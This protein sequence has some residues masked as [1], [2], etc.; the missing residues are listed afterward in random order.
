[1]LLFS[2]EGFGN[3][4]ELIR[5]PEGNG[6][7]VLLDGLFSPGEWEDA[8]K[9][10]IHQNVN[11][12]LKRYGGHVFIG[13]KITPYKTSVV[14]MFISP[15]GESIHHL[16]TS[17]QIGE[18]LVN[19][20][21]GPWDNPSF[22]WGYSVDWYANEIRWDNGKMEDLM[23]KGKD[24]NEAQEMSYFT[25][26]GFEFQIRQSKFSSDQWLFRIE[27]PMAPD[28]DKPVIYPSGTEMK[29]TK[30]WVR[31]ELDG[32]GNKAKAANRNAEM[33]EISKAIDSCIGWFKTKDFKLLFNTIANDPDY[34]SIHPSNRIVRGFEQFKKNAEIY[35]DPE[36]QYVRHDVNDL[37]INISDS[38]DIAWFYCV[39][40]DI[41]TWKGKPATWENTRWT[42]VLEKREGRWVIIQ[43]H[44][45]FAAD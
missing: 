45:S 17:A 8:E 30:G 1:M 4:S 5:V 34:L 25:Y 12:Y 14:D 40:D 2:D 36:F 7:P 41:N 43:Q 20:D 42:G 15:D 27:V 38:G 37:T 35:K 21:S 26:D 28:F 11:L 3:A 33:Q 13:I 10:A 24:R 31:L 29:S 23:K 44:F 19:K 22:V 18:R 9:I 39:L 32:G 16:H 6:R